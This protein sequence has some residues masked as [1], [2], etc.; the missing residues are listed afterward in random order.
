MTENKE[1]VTSNGDAIIKMEKYADKVCA[2]RCNFVE[3]NIRRSEW[4]RTDERTEPYR[5]YI[6]RITLRS[7]FVSL[8]ATVLLMMTFVD[9]V[10]VYRAFPNTVRD[11]KCVCLY[12]AVAVCVV[13]HFFCDCFH[14]IAWAT[15][16][17]RS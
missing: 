11:D 16:M 2:S 7:A 1:R 8:S 13:T 10:C 15:Q 17:R 6:Y 4:W 9:H 14:C 3:C 12:V 5:A